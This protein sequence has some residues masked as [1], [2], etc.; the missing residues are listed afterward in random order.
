MTDPG[1]KRRRSGRCDP[2]TCARR[3]DLP[4]QPVPLPHHRDAPR[5]RR[6]G[7]G[8]RARAPRRRQRRRRGRRRQDLPLEL[9]LPA[10]HRR[11]HAPR[12]PQQPR[13]DGADRGDRAPEHPADLRLGA[14][15]RQLPVRHAAHGHDAARGDHEAQPDAAR[16][17]Q[18]ARAGARGRSATLHDAR[19]DPPRLHAAQHPR[20][21]GRERRLPVRLRSRDVA[22]RR[23]RQTY[24]TYYRA[25]SSARRAGRSRP[26]RST[27]PDGLPINT[28]LDIYAIGGALHGLFTEQ[29]L[30]GEA[31][32]MWALLD[33][34]RR[35]RRRRWREQGPLPRQR[36]RRAAPG[37][38]GL[39]RARSGAAVPVGAG[40]RPGAAR[41]CCASSDDAAPTPLRR[42]KTDGRADH[43]ASARTCSR[44][45]AAAARSNDHRR[46]RRRRR[47]RG[48]RLGL[49]GRDAASAA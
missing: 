8:L 22:R 40:R 33:P 42:S 28:S 29:L 19:L 39:P 15:R 47:G 12:S 23:R 45:A 7:H 46:G 38:R 24:R 17:H 11:G 18:A 44:S 34:D 35:G 37:D 9:P 6:H 13:R 3:S 14:D 4:L 10:P 49:R 43:R 32:D 48:P 26:R 41:R 25:G 27:R 16:P 31:D 21:R 5:R 2:T 30:Y 1:S 36:S 20:R